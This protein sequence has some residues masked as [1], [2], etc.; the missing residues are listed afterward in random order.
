MR[1]VG[2]PN[3][4]SAADYNHVM[5]HV[6]PDMDKTGSYRVAKGRTRTKKESGGKD[7]KGSKDEDRKVGTRTR[8]GQDEDRKGQDRDKKESTTWDRRARGKR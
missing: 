4:N 5:A 2:R 6:I 3:S 7:K 8:K 1:E